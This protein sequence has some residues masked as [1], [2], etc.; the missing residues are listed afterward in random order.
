[1]KLHWK[2]AMACY[3]APET[4]RGI[5]WKAR[6]GH[7]SWMRGEE[8]GPTLDSFHVIL[9]GWEG[10]FELKKIGCVFSLEGVCVSELT[11]TL[12]HV[13]SKLCVCVCV[14][15]RWNCAD[16]WECVCVCVF[17]ES[18]PHLEAAA[19]LYRDWQVHSALIISD[20]VMWCKCKMSPGLSSRGGE[21]ETHTGRRSEGVG[22]W[23]ERRCEEA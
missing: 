2:F 19:A 6:G 5:V 11:G 22:G 20:C 7:M 9:R 17:A 15:V 18:P 16:R 10:H 14:C 4:M 21:E 12:R 23:T 1:M 13:E 3:K 8:S